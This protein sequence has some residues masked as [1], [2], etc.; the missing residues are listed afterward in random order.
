MELFLLCLFHHCILEGGNLFSS[1]TDLWKEEFCP[2]MDHTESLSPSDLD[3]IE[4]WDRV[5]IFCTW[6]DMS[7]GELEGR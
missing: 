7:F 2:R 6:E 5:N 1:I 4:C 3:E